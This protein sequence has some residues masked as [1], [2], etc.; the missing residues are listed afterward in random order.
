MTKLIGWKSTAESIR[1]PTDADPALAPFIEHI[2]SQVSPYT[3]EFRADWLLTDPEA[4]IWRTRTKTT[5]LYNG[6]WKSTIDVNWAQLLSDGQLLTDSC[7][8]ELLSTCR[9][10]SFLYRQGM[11]GDIPALST[12]MNFNAFLLRLCNWL[13]LERARY[14][15]K[16]HAFA[17]LDNEGVRKI[18]IALGR[19]GWTVVLRRIEFCLDAIHREVFGNP[20]PAELLTSTHWPKSLRHQVIDWLKGNNKY[21]YPKNAKAHNGFVSRVWVSSLINVSYSQLNS[22][23]L[24]LV[25]RQFEP[26]HQHPSLL[27]PTDQRTEYPGHH[28]PLIEDAKTAAGNET[29]IKHTYFLF[30][31]LFN[32]YRHLPDVLPDPTG[33]QLKDAERAGV[34]LTKLRGHTSFIPVDIGVAY[35]NEALRWVWCYGDALVDYYLRVHEKRE[36]RRSNAGKIGNNEEF[37]KTL[38]DGTPLPESL[39]A[40]GF[41]FRRFKTKKHRSFE[42]WRNAPSLHEALEVW[43]GAVV[44]LLGLMKPGRDSEITTLPFNCLLRT[45]G[46]NY[47][48]DSDLAKRTKAES[49]ART[50]GK[51][52]PEIVARAI[53]Q[54]RKLNRGLVSINKEPDCHLREML[55]YLPSSSKLRT[56]IKMDRQALNNYLDHFCDYVNL[57]TDRYGRRWYLRIH[58]MRKWF[59]LL[60]FWSGRY[61]VLDAGR[62]ISGHTDVKH[63]YAYIEREFPGGKIGELEAECA[64]DLL[65]QYDETRVVAD[66]EEMGL[67]ELH[68]Q[69]LQHFNVKRLN[70]VKEREWHGL[71]Q[72]LFEQEYH[73]EPITL[74]TNDD[75]K[76][77]CIAIRQGSRNES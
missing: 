42:E 40:A 65:A 57:P 46:G 49:R 20:C 38:L 33:F 56:G 37:D 13:V 77:T 29:V 10:A 51:P 53:Q 41:Q 75:Q 25:L 39:K 22:P 27:L 44:V 14:H 5:R 18:F 26:K 63:L 4:P 59:L 73:L 58:E 32:L 55:F 72:E 19:G 68:R 74:T 9:R 45:Q 1:L 23:Y 21:G 54:V 60:L 15:P 28:V 71:V 70:L 67:A 61:D 12:W 62:W 3:G 30:N 11:V 8:S 52:I 64:I 48:L 43:V 36:L 16:Q 76:R 35:L 6:E 34:R 2:K 66:G 50:G 7:Y 31:L 69:V 17:L 47:W 24:S